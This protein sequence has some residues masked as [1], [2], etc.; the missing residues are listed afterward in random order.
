MSDAQPSRNLLAVAWG[1]V[2]T[3]VEPVLAS[4]DPWRR[5]RLMRALGWDLE[6]ISGVDAHTFEEW[7]DTIRPAL[8]A[9][10]RALDESKWDSLGAISD[11]G[12]AVGKAIGRV[13]ALPPALNDGNLPDVPGLP[14]ALAD[15]LI[16]HLVLTYL[17]RR[18]AWAVPLL[19]LLGLVT[20]T[21][22]AAPSPPMPAGD[23]PVRLPRRRAALH[24]DRLVDVVADPGGYLRGLYAPDGLDT[25]EKVDAMSARLLPRLA[26]LLQAFGVDAAH[27]V[28]PGIGPDLG[29][30]GL[31]LADNLLRVRFGRPDGSTPDGSA[32]ALTGDPAP[33]SAPAVAADL[34]YR[35]GLTLAL[36]SWDG[37]LTAI[38]APTGE[39]RLAGSFGNWNV[40]TAL[41]GAGAAVAV[42][43]A[44][45][46]V[47]DGGPEVRFD[48]EIARI[49]PA[50]EAGWLIGAPSGTHL[51]IG[52]LV[53]RGRGALGTGRDDIDLTVHA[54]RAEL[55]IAP[56]DG[57]G[58]LARLL[59]AGGL[60]I[61]FDLGLG[62]SSRTG[63]HLAGAAA[64]SAD[65]P[66]HLPL[67]GGSLEG[68][69]L[70]LT[71]DT[72]TRTVSLTAATTLN[73]AIGP[74]RAVVTNT[75]V[76][77]DLSFP[78]PA[79]PGTAEPTAGN[80][81]GA[82]LVPR[83]KS[84]DGVGL[85]VSNGIVSGGGYLFVDETRGR[86]AGVLALS[87]STKD[88]LAPARGIAL[89]A[90]AI[91]DTRQPDGSR[92]TDTDG[93]STF[94]LLMVG[95]F[96]WYPGLPLFWGITMT[97]LG[98]VVGHNRRSNPEE[99]GNAAR[100]GTLDSLLFPTDVVGRAPAIV[101]ALSRIFPAD[102]TG[103]VIG[104][105]VRL[106]MLSGQ[107]V[108]DLAVVVEFPDPV[109]I[110]VLGRL[111]IDFKVAGRLRLDAAGVVDLSRKQVDLHAGLVDS[112][113]F[114]R[115]ASGQMLVHASW[116]G[117]K[118]FVATIGGYHPR[119]IPPVN[120]PV[121]SRFTIQ[122]L[123]STQGITLKAYLA[124]TSNSAQF[125]GE[126]LV[127]FAG[128]GF[129]ID[130]RATLD[131]LFQF[132][133]FWFDVALTA[134]VSLTFKGTDLLV[135]D[136][137]IAL[138][139]PGL[140]HGRGHA[141][142]KFLWWETS[143]SFD[144]RHG[145]KPV[146]RDP[147][148][149]NVA[150]LLGEA[151][152]AASAWEAGPGLPGP[153]AVTLRSV[154]D[155]GDALLLAPGATLAVRQN[156][157]PLDVELT[158]FGTSRITGPN[159]FTISEVRAGTGD[160]VVS[161]TLGQTIMDDF[162]PG[163]FQDLSPEQQWMMPGFERQAAGRHVALPDRTALPDGPLTV[164]VGLDG[165][166]AYDR[167]IIDDPAAA[168]REMPATV[169]A[170]TARWV[171]PATADGALLAAPAPPTGN[172]L[173]RF[174]ANGPAARARTA[175]A[176]RFG[177]AGLD[178]VDRGPAW[179]PVRNR[180]GN[181]RPV[182]TGTVAGRSAVTGTAAAPVATATRAAELASGGD[183]SRLIRRA[184][185]TVGTPTIAPVHHEKVS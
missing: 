147:S 59:P 30:A 173:A 119:Y 53:L 176:A 107:I 148:N 114:G 122:L 58:L 92:F 27:G 162:A 63:V 182:G 183:R 87:L 94:S 124:V 95:T 106:E 178:L 90:T 79:P 72:S 161:G 22:E 16:D 75:G 65:Y 29:E 83:F 8:E 12:S 91:L 11:T 154:T 41:T 9:L 19:V 100:A 132:K 115:P 101:A 52:Q 55:V 38:V 150:G 10:G 71:A 164:F 169:T 137:A 28:R 96:Q 103:T 82:D 98:L 151:L 66:L 156:L 167:A 155:A 113:L 85:S 116:G 129:V 39:T 57:D 43:S 135:I 23:A 74:L 184:S 105:M 123:K 110:S 15:D 153:E 3:L 179:L 48:A 7:V 56:G 46:T 102:P 70:A 24:L 152:S 67:P 54:G 25:P 109:R 131:A 127:K 14:A 5:A 81:G 138:S 73:L 49:A 17:Q 181:R 128:G 88:G 35:L 36:T 78:A 126:V 134:R 32:P 40:T 34:P 120:L 61:G 180:S 145:D 143:A 118:S 37:R 165:D 60:R 18:V 140:W 166:D 62:W 104:A 86:Y 112:R 89:Q 51:A 2:L 33:A 160:G 44:G 4:A 77:L 144:W 130:G 6:A 21:A 168:G 97:G 157:I 117:Q 171:D 31:R 69:R 93:N 133:P 172:L 158:R 99:I 64:L 177:G 125:G 159:R 50:D 1:E 68:L 47:T 45:V 149:V 170:P 139:G 20:P 26:A 13:G 142:I 185:V 108:A 84:P 174:A 146:E 136:L 80:L 121:P 141:K 111:V 42:N 163:Q 175:G 76:R